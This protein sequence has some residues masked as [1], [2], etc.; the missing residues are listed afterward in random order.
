MELDKSVEDSAFFVWFFIGTLFLIMAL[1]FREHFWK[2]NT[3]NNQFIKIYKKIPSEIEV[4]NFIEN[5]FI[6]RNIYLNENYG[7][8]NSNLNYEKQHDNFL[9]LKKM[10]VI[11]ESEFAEKL[12]Q[13]DLVFKRNNAKIGF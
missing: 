13:L 9:W 3:S 1:L 12:Q 7:K 11:S 8:I 6:K 5:L 4:D 2:I 10:H